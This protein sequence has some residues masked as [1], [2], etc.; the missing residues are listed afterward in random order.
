[1][2][3]NPWFWILLMPY[4]AFLAWTAYLNWKDDSPYG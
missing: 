3:E 4:A 2:T 1:M